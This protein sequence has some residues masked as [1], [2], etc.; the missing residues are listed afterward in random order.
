MEEIMPI[1]EYR[2][3]NCEQLIEEWQKSFTERDV[4]CPICGTKAKRI[5]SNTSFVL[6]GS[7]WYVTDYGSNHQGSNDGNKDVSKDDKS[8]D[9]PATTS[10]VKDITPTTCIS[11][12]TDKADIAA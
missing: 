11:S 7:G 12:C 1:Y 9:T 10:T 2:C 8:K 4:N 3:K 6:K 5:I